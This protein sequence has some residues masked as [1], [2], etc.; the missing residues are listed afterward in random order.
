MDC[1]EHP[2]SPL[3]RLP[4]ET[5]YQILK[6][7]LTI[8]NT[9]PARPQ[10]ALVN[11]V[12]YFDPSWGILAEPDRTP[13]WIQESDPVY[14]NDRPGRASQAALQATNL[15]LRAETRQILAQM[16][17]ELDVMYL[18]GCGMFP[19]WVTPVP[20]LQ[21]PIPM[22]HVRVR[23]FRGPPDPCC[24]WLWME[25]VYRRGKL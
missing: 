8:T 2:I 9:A 4:A 6:E 11:R 7:V 13:I 5:R 19:T 24:N 15:Q 17:P 18:T 22:L 1:L 20:V 14:T 16:Q 21:D 12:R 25:K 23:G 10:D 3:I